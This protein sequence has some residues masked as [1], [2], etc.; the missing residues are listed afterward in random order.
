MLPSCAARP[1]SIPLFP[2]AKPPF[3]VPPSNNQSEQLSIPRILSK[4]QAILSS[5]GHRTFQHSLLSHLYRNGVFVEFVCLLIYEWTRFLER[6]FSCSDEHKRKKIR[7]Y[8]YHLHFRT[9]YQSEQRNPFPGCNFYIFFLLSSH[10]AIA[11]N[12]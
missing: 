3:S 12:V 2:Q 9:F 7:V 4:A 6:P 11:S 5:G 10:I 1:D 8:S